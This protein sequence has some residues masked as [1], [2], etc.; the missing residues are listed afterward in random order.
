MSLDLEVEMSEQ[1][2]AAHPSWGEPQHSYLT[3]AT[4]WIGL[5]GLVI[6]CLLAL[7]AVGAF[8]T[9]RP[10][11]IAQ[12]AVE[13]AVLPIEGCAA[14]ATGERLLIS[15]ELRAGK[16][17]VACRTVRPFVAMRGAK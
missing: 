17:Q 2:P 15:I 10:A 1:H 9:M 16:F 6:V 12:V 8:R 7:D 5:P 14:P 3:S 4:A 11:A 13:R